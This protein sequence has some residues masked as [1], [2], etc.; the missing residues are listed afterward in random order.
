MKVRRFFGFFLIFSVAMAVIAVG[1]I[2]GQAWLQDLPIWARVAAGAGVAFFV[3]FLYIVADQVLLRDP[4]RYIQHP[5]NVAREFNQRTLGLSDDVALAEAIGG[6][7]AEWLAVYRSGWLLLTPRE[8]ALHIRPVPGKGHLPEMPIELQRA[9]GL[10]QLLNQRRAPVRQSEVD[11]LEMIGTEREWLKQL[12]VEV[13]APIFEAGL[14]TAILAVGPKDNG[15]RFQDTEVDLVG[16]IAGLAAPALKSARALAEIRSLNETIAKLNEALKEKAVPPVPHDST[17]TDFLAIASHE[18]RTPITQLLGFADLLGAMTRENTIDRASLAQTTDSIVRACARLND[19]INQILDMA[20][21]DANA[22]SLALKPTSMENIL[23][24]AIEPYLT[25]MR[26]RKIALNVTGLK[27]L[28]PIQADEARLAQAF[29]QLT[30]NAIKYTPDGGRVDISVRVLPAE[31]TLPARFHLIFADSGIG[32][33]QQHHKLI[34]DKFYR[35]GS[36]SL[37]STSTTKFMGAG[38]GLGLPI[39]KGVIER[40]GGRIWVE[41]PGHDAK[42]FPGSRFHVL[43]P[44]HPPVF[45]MRATTSA[46]EGQGAKERRSAL[47][48]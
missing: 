20:Q 45:D 13:Y 46:D 11:G 43:L 16:L 6:M 24:L 8:T 27:N 42:K 40:H 38:P 2:Q 7:L 23:R 18:L 36:S 12:G 25:A 28:P 21:L 32:I 17:R 14:L 5:M 48:R 10:L 9:N 41:S 4:I 44:I 31:N 29:S 33:D 47:L 15:S 26:E 39:A 3:L 30:S 37:H 1:L 19:V 22:V 35:V 34:F